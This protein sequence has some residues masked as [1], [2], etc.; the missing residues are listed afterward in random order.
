MPQDYQ[1]EKLHILKGQKS[2]EHGKKSKKIMN[3]EGVGLI[4]NF[5]D[6]L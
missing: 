6:A 2:R 5:E 1:N 3:L 4:N